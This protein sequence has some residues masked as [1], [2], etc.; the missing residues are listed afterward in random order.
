VGLLILVGLGFAVRELLR[1]QGKDTPT[2]TADEDAAG[3]E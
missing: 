3:G 2:G 1:P